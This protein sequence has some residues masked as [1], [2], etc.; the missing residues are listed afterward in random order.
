MQKEQGVSKN[1]I[2]FIVTIILISLTTIS[3]SIGI[4]EFSL[5]NDNI[6]PTNSIYPT[7]V[8]ESSIP[9]KTSTLFATSTPT[10]TPTTT[11]TQALIEFLPCG[12]PK[13]AVCYYPPEIN[14]EGML[15]KLWIRNLDIKRI[16]YVTIGNIHFKCIA[17]NT[18]SNTVFCSGPKIL[19]QEW[20]IQLFLPNGDLISSGRIVINL[21]F[22]TPIKKQ[23][24]STEENISYPN[25]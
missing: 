9:S 8:I 24:T 15:V 13:Q 10:T 6:V 14:N 22:A 25:P 5:N 7:N 19:N 2:Y 3:C 12:E 21:A 11:P 18:A 17:S 23:P 16:P 1:K 20:K 4:S